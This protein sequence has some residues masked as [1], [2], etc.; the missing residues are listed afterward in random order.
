MHI[1]GNNL[2]EAEGF[3]RVIVPLRHPRDV[4]ISW[5]KRY[6]RRGYDELRWKEWMPAWEMLPTIKGHFFFLDGRD[7]ELKRLSE[8]VGVELKTDWTPLNH[9]PEQPT[10]NWITPEELAMAEEIYL[11]L[12]RTRTEDGRDQSTA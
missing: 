11:H 7:E 1:V 12:A 8:Y 5:N 2:H 9:Y 6:E 4:A 3:D 10:Q